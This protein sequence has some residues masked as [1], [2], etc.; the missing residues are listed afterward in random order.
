VL[1]TEDE[2]VTV[3]EDREEPAIDPGAGRRESLAVLCGPAAPVVG[4]SQARTLN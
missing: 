1:A 4:G 3:P 2:V